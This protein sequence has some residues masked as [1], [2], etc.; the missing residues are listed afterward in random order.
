MNRLIYTVVNAAAFLIAILPFGILYCISDFFYLII[1]YLVRYRRK[2]VRKNL[3]NAF[4]EKT[5]VEILK[6]E[7]EFYRRFCDY[8][9]ETL[10]LLHISDSEMK[11]RFVFKNLE[12]AQRFLDI[13]QPTVLMLG[14]YG[15]W[16]WAPSLSLHLKTDA[17][18]VGGQVYRPLDNKA[19]DRFFL[20]LRQRFHSKG[21]TKHNVYRDI[22]NFR[23]TNTNWMI[24]FMSDQK[25]SGNQIPHRMQFLNQDTPVLSGTEKI[26]QHAKAAVC[27]VDIT[28]LKRGYY[29]GSIRVISENA[30]ETAEFEITEKYIRLLEETIVRN[31][32]G[33]LWTH[34]RWRLKFKELS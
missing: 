28:C 25:P 33:Y 5:Q 22:V 3:N 34:N 2:L 12:T 32:S 4:P 27:Y 9:V 29:E 14:H 20:N 19:F 21:F 13:R 17:N 18:T 10:K 15:N 1:Y 6:I 8:F 7:K 11:K 23:K 30:A 31:P 24:G 26:A 16:E